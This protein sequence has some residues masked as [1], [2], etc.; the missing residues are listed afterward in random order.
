MA[1]SGGDSNQNQ[2]NKHHEVGHKS[3][4]QSDALY[5]YILETSVYPREPESMKELREVTAKHPC[6]YFM[7]PHCCR[8]SILD[9]RT[10]GSIVGP[11][12]RRRL[13]IEDFRPANLSHLR[14]QLRRCL[15]LCAA[16]I[17][18]FLTF[19]AP[20]RMPQF[21]HPVRQSSGNEAMLASINGPTNMFQSPQLITTESNKNT[22]KTPQSMVMFRYKSKTPLP[23]DSH[24]FAY[25]PAVAK[26]VIDFCHG[27][28]QM[29]H[30]R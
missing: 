2:A 17:G 14:P 29:L 7:V 8:R 26:E 10:K 22:S 25:Q 16:A 27:R 24:P 28:I 15:F 18:S 9:P 5:Q 3:L 4:L 30:A 13:P 23:L 21:L 11:Q 19:V 20:L 1:E 12:R 6:V